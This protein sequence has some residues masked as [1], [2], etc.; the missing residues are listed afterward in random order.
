MSFRC[1]VVSTETTDYRSFYLGICRSDVS[2]RYMA[3]CAMWELHPNVQ[4]ILVK[5]AVM[6]FEFSPM[7]LDA[8]IRVDHY[9]QSPSMTND[10]LWRHLR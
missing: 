1:T 9:N 7:F 3:T 8:H 4:N 10:K 2:A 5:I 6:A